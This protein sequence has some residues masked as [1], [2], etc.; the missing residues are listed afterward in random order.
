M[1]IAGSCESYEILRFATLT[2]LSNIKFFTDASY[3]T[4]SR[5]MKQIMRRKLHSAD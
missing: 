5:T 3:N 2:L 4:L 1:I